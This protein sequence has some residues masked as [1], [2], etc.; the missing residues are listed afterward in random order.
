MCDNERKMFKMTT[1][2]DKASVLQLRD[3]H[4]SFCLNF[5]KNWKNDKLYAQQKY[6][7]H[8]VIK[9]IWGGWLTLRYTGIRGERVVWHKMR[10]HFY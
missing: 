4:G 5:K 1:H 8:T 2:K 7:K 3:W 6:I 10:F 9:L